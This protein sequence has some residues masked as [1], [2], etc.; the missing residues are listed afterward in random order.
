MQ[1]SSDGQYPD[2]MVNI[3]RIGN[4]RNQLG[5]GP[6]WDM[7]SKALYWVD[8]LAGIVYRRL[9]NEVRKWHCGDMVGSL[10]VV[11]DERLVVATQTGLKFLNFKDGQLDPI[12]DPETD[13]PDTR[14]NDGK[15]D[16]AGNFL[17]GTM[18][19]RIRDR[20]LGSLYRLRPDLTLEV[21]LTDVVV[22]NGPCFSP[23]GRTFYFNDGRRR[24]LAFDYDPNGP[25]ANQR[26]FFDGE[27][28]GTGSDGA[29]VDTDGNIWAALIGSGEIGCITPDGRLVE[30]IAMP[31]RL[32]SSVMFGGEYLDELFVTSISDSG[33]RTSDEPGAGGLYRV[34]GLGARG[35]PE[36]RFAL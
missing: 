6:L 18:G 20:G 13:N 11:D 28:H 29:T 24:I 36:T 4:T 19:I 2:P 26:T 9:G 7:T 21:L 27:T 17:A 16:H 14:F 33:N 8:S 23:D 5:E 15:T 35:L 1:T 12:T 32:P 31:V 34:T 25:L 30:R 22:S 10:A 3:E